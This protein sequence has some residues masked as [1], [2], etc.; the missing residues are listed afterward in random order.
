MIENFLFQLKRIHLLV[1]KY[2]VF[3]YTFHSIDFARFV[4][5]NLKHLTKRPLSYN[6]DQLKILQFCIFFV[7]S[8]ENGSG[9]EFSSDRSFNFILILICLLFLSVFVIKI[10]ILRILLISKLFAL[11]EIHQASVLRLLVFTLLDQICGSISKLIWRESILTFFQI[12]FGRGKSFEVVFRN[13][14]KLKIF[15]HGFNISFL[16]DLDYGIASIFTKLLP[17]F[18][19]P[20]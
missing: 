13:G 18:H 2:N 16:K 9:H 7:L 4:M 10:L 5:L 17:H 15:L 8:F 19:L 11:F 3:S 1:F 14:E 6:L 20:V 12:F